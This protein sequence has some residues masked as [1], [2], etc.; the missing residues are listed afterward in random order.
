MSEEKGVE[1]FKI[2]NKAIEANDFEDYLWKLSKKNDYES[3]AILMDNL[4]V[5]KTPNVLKEYEKLDIN[6]IANVSYSPDFNP[7]E[8]CFS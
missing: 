2:Y 3:I 8:S 4:P 1:L 7:I 6:R 5:H